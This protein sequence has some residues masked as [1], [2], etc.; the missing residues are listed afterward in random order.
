MRDDFIESFER[1]SEGIILYFTAMSHPLPGHK[2]R[3]AFCMDT[4]TITATYLW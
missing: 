4:M 2:E 3:G 1:G